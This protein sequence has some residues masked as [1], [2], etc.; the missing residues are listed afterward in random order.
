MPLLAY[1]VIA[2][3]PSE[4]AAAEYAAWL[5]DGHL[6]A[7][8]AGGARSAQVVRIVEPPE[9]VEIEVRYLF[10]SRAAFDRYVRETAPRL[11][12]EGLARFGPASGVSFRRTVGEVVA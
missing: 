4:A 10:E 3:L 8:I 2:T 7:V 5:R 9:P 12:A 6:D 1:T 11:R